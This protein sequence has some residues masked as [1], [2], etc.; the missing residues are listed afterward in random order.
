MNKSACGVVATL[1][2]AACGSPDAPLA[3]ARSDSIPL[4][5]ELRIGVL[6]GPMETMFGSV[7]P[8]APTADG[9]V[10]IVDTQVPVIRTYDTDGAYLGDIGRKGQ[11]PGEYLTVAAMT[12]LGDGRLMIWDEGNQRVSWF[13]ATGTFLDSRPLRAG[14][15]YDTF[16]IARDGTVYT[17]VGGGRPPAADPIEIVGDWSRIDPNGTVERLQEIPLVNSEGP[18]YVLSGRGGY[19][20]PFTVMTLA[21]MGPDGSYYEV[22]NDRYRIRHVH[23]DGH[24]SLIT[25][26]EPRIVVS[27]EEAA[28]WQ[29]RSESMAQRPGSDRSSF[30]P[31]PDVKPYIRHIKTDLDGRLWVS[32]YTEKAYMPY[33]E[34]E[35]ADRAEQGLPSYNWRDRLRWDVYAPDD[36]YLGF[37]TFPMRTS[38]AAARGAEV[39]AIEAG[40]FREDYVVRY[41]MSGGEWE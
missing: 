5:E 35:A 36:T 21:T 38:L 15:Q 8:I 4:V 31:I 26:D 17:R 33:T 30:F 14:G 16:V 23:P 10:H 1:V 37:V 13:D 39:W 25:R 34:A 29:A 9:R 7:G 41:R 12:V 19:Y 32:R 6:D 24:E 3:E 40:P 18:R 22:R 11:G 28:E 27:P 2:L 20:R